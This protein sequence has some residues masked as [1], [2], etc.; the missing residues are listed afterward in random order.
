M[1]KIEL[2]IVNN[3]IKF[4][5]SV[6]LTSFLHIAFRGHLP[7]I[8]HEQILE[9]NKIKEKIYFGYV[10]FLKVQIF[11]KTNREKSYLNSVMLN[12]NFLV[13]YL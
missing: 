9:L 8:I 3:K 1:R 10:P 5:K 2:R 11:F 13:C 7:F 12:F 6:K 4:R